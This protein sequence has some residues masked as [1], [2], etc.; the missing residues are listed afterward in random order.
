[1]IYK[2]SVGY[3]L[4][5]CHFTEKELTKMQSKAHRAMVAHCGYIR[6]TSATVLYAPLSLTRGAGFF[7][8]Y[9]DQGYGQLKL[10]MKFGRS[11]HT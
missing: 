4:P 3:A 2:L 1:M 11:K 7:H 9:D 10:F 8:L 6:N 5:T